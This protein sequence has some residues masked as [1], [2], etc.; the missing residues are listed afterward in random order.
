MYR[1]RRLIILST[2]S[3]LLAQAERL[4][5]IFPTAIEIV[6][7][8]M[9]IEVVLIYSL[10]T[11]KGELILSAYRGVPR[12]FAL[13]VD[14]MKLGE[15]VNGRVAETGEPLM[16]KDAAKDPR[17]SRDAVRREGLR[18]QLVVPMK[19][20]GQVVGTICVASRQKAEF[21]T[22]EMELLTAIGNQIGRSEEHTSELQ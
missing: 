18:A 13:G 20:R 4:E 1:S 22:E 8:V 10:D 19:S 2:L 3:G 16:V 5:D 17:L 7:D 14:K 6:A 12:E 15:G 21:S 9:E 11:R